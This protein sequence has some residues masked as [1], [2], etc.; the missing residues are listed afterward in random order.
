MGKTIS[1]NNKRER[2]NKKKS[3][4]QNN[5]L[6][7]STNSSK[8]KNNYF[9]RSGNKRESKSLSLSNGNLL[10]DDIKNNLNKKLKNINLVTI[11][12]N[13][14]DRK[15]ESNLSD[16]NLH[17]VDTLINNGSNNKYLINISEKNIYEGERNNTFNNEDNINFFSPKY[18]LKMNSFLI[19]NKRNTSLME[20][21]STLKTINYFSN[22]KNMNFIS[23]SN[24]QISTDTNF[25]N[26]KNYTIINNYNNNNIN[27]EIINKIYSPTNKNKKSFHGLFHQ[28]VKEN[29]D[30]FEKK[31]D[32]SKRNFSLL[33]LKTINHNFKREIKLENNN[34]SNDNKKYNS[35]NNSENNKNSNNNSDKNNFINNSENN[36]NSNNN[37]DNNN[38]NNNSDKNSNNNSDKNSNNISNKNSNNNSNKNSNNNSNKNSNNN[39]NKNSNNNSDNNSNNN[40]ANNSNNNSDNNNNFFNIRTPLKH[41]KDKYNKYNNEDINNSLLLDNQNNEKIN[42]ENNSEKSNN[43][44]RRE[45]GFLKKLR[46]QI[47]KSKFGR[48][49]KKKRKKV[50]YSDKIIF[51]KKTINEHESDTSSLTRSPEKMKKKKINKNLKKQLSKISEISNKFEKRKKTTIHYNK[52]EQ[53]LE[54]LKQIKEIMDGDKKV[55]NIKK[56]STQNEKKG[57]IIFKKLIDCFDNNNYIDIDASDSLSFDSEISTYRNKNKILKSNSINYTKLRNASVVLSVKELH[58]KINKNLNDLKKQK[59]INAF[60]NELKDYEEHITILKISKK[61]ELIHN[62]VCHISKLKSLFYKNKKYDNNRNKIKNNKY[63]YDI[64]EKNVKKFEF[65]IHKIIRTKNK[66]IENIIPSY[67]NR[68]IFK[69]HLKINLYD[70]IIKGRYLETNLGGKELLFNFDNKNENLLNHFDKYRRKTF[71]YTKKIHRHLISVLPIILS[72][73]ALKFYNRFLIIDTKT[74]QDTDSYK[75]GLSN[76]FKRTTKHLKLIRYNNT[77]INY[78]SNEKNLNNH[79]KHRNSFRFLRTRLITKPNLIRANSTF[80][81]QSLKKDWKKKI[82]ILKKDFYN[83][84]RDSFEN[85]IMALRKKRKENKLKNS[86]IHKKEK[87]LYISPISNY[88]NINERTINNFQLR[89]YDKDI[90]IFR[91]LKIKNDLL[92]K[93]ENYQ[94]ALFLFIKHDDYYNFKETFEKYKPNTELIDNDGNSLL[95]IAVQCDLIK[96]VKYLLNQGAYPNTQNYKLNSPLHYALTHNNFELADILIKYGADENL[97]NGEGLTAWQ[98]L[99]SENTII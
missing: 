34:I 53:K 88:N 39:S 95:N 79:N 62:C 59:L 49:P 51:L 15:K 86:I 98:C 57:N 75:N 68:I 14:N 81:H 6:T 63:Y 61:N 16:K 24:D 72:N 3:F 92:K 76:I 52:L 29:I 74:F 54:S 27:N 50:E 69:N 82:N 44:R 38:S 5:N 91:T 26:N 55:R 1:E 83:R 89:K 42:L 2:K 43:S 31:I 84:K 30:N 25:V 10:S 18:N 19:N 90:T 48:S 85:N 4:L 71:K 21:S 58:F 36:K 87:L 22:K 77:N 80:S 32:N 9:L 7:F 56:T 13:N 65:D 28:S 93:C 46:E 12:N 11:I 17:K 73:E 47:E 96:I 66:I 64:D 94:E 23:S 8:N 60:T 37:S 41:N 70:Q 35:N 99:N 33:R 45:S 20:H 78:D 40:S 97:K 67:F